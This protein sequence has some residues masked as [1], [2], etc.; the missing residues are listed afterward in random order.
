MAQLVERRTV[1]EQLVIIRLQVRS[2]LAGPIS[3]KRSIVEPIRRVEQ[4][5]DL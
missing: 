1:G 3:V 4:S 5:D 2:Q